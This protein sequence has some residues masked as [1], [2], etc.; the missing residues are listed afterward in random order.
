MCLPIRLLVQGLG[1]VC[2]MKGR[3]AEVDGWLA[4]SRGKGIGDLRK[5]SQASCLCWDA[6]SQMAAFPSSEGGVSSSL[7]PERSPVQ[8]LRRPS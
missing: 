6:C 8:H 7:M 4:V 5:P 2:G 3:A 1:V